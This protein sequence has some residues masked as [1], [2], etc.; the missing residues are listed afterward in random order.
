MTD[1]LYVVMV[2]C[3]LVAITEW[4]V[5]K[6][7]L[8]HFGTALLVILITAI[9]ANIGILPAGSTEE[10]PVPVYIAIFK[11]LAP[12]SIFWL[13]LRV[14][15]K[16]ILKAGLPMLILFIISALAT[17]IGIVI[18]M[19]IINGDHTIGE[20]YAPLGGM[21][22][23]TYT[24]GSV[25]F[26]AVALHYDVIRDG[27]LYAGSVAV[28]NIITTIW[29][30][31]TLAFPRLLARFWPS[32][33]NHVVANNG[34]LT[35]VEEDTED[36]HPMDLGLVIA[37]GAAALW[38]SDWLAGISDIPSIIIITIIALIIAQL[39]ISRSIKGAQVLGMFAVYL[40]LAVIGAFCDL[41]ALG[42]MGYLGLVIFAM[43]GIGVI[44]HG[45]ITFLTA[46][47]MNMDLDT[48]SMVSQANV[49]GATSALA[50]AR[51]L[52]RQDLVLP[53]VLLGSLGTGIGTF[54][55][56]LVSGQILPW[57]M[58]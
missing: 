5:Q 55:G 8:K 54:L 49:G 36:L 29:M 17:T 23:G 57:L 39:P 16:E 50:L 6:T 35:G 25:N 47:A 51:S 42:E 11:Y 56:F 21:F 53:A 7:F 33:T 12:I 22:T 3:L 37:L 38:I 44:I 28:D 41:A 58:G 18:G 14:N 48:A 27:N 31:A 24:G 30:I 46:R 10:N 43:A 32:G 13:L 4:L 34:P 20:S 52:G 2:L 9:L 26:N 1:G 45:T 15:L 19:V 40:F